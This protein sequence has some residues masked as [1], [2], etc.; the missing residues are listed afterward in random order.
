M[1]YAFDTTNRDE[2]YAFLTLLMSDSTI[3]PQEVVKFGRRYWTFGQLYIA[4][5]AVGKYQVETLRA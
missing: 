4:T 2:L 3:T 5:G 1:R